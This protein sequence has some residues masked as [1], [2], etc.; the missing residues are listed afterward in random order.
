[1]KAKETLASQGEFLQTL[2]TVFV[3]PK[4]SGDSPKVLKLQLEVGEDVCFKPG[5]W[6]PLGTLEIHVVESGTE[7]D[8]VNELRLATELGAY[9]WNLPS[10]DS[11]RG[12]LK[13][14]IEAGAEGGAG[15]EATFSHHLQQAMKLAAG[16]AVRCGL[17]KPVIDPSLVANLPFSR[18]TTIV[19]DTS[20]VV[21][22]GLSFVVDFLGPSVRARVPAVVSMELMTRTDAYFSIR[23]GKKLKRLQR[24][25]GL[26]SHIFSQAGQRVL[27]RL[28][29]QTEIEVERP[30]MGADPLRGIAELGPDQDDKNLNVHTVIRSYADRLILETAIHH[31]EALEP[32]HDLVVLTADQGLARATQSEG[33]R[34]FFIDVSQMPRIFDTPLPGTVFAPFISRD[35]SGRLHTIPLSELVW[36]LASSFGAARLVASSSGDWLEVRALGNQ[37]PWNPFHSS[38]DLLWVRFGG[39]RLFP[40]DGLV[41]VPSHVVPV[42]TTETATP[43]PDPARPRSRAKKDS[44]SRLTGSYRFGLTSLLRLVDTLGTRPDATRETIMEVLNIQNFNNYLG[45]KNFLQSGGLIGEIDGRLVVLRPLVDLRE[46]LRNADIARAQT[47]LL[48]IPSYQAFLAEL[49]EGRPILRAGVASVSNSALD[50]YSALADLVA[51]ASEIPEEGLY[52]TPKSPPAG[53]FPEPAF[54]AYNEVRR[55]ELYASTGAW[56]EGLIRR[57]I[58][59]VVARERLGQARALGRVRLYVEGS[60]P[61]ESHSRHKVHLLDTGGVTLSVREASL[62]DGS[63]LTPGVASVSLRLEV[64]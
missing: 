19:V 63:F 4:R 25:K 50:S 5:G 38:E 14:L 32:G 62:Y 35:G 7:S 44:G 37:M 58:H 34:P 33:L 57:G 30:R 22:G 24:I 49:R 15:D 41:E 27:T 23:R 53:E 51:A 56:L 18:P 52:A 1:M 31:R 17:A 21:H 45:Y 61:D 2:S 8:P 16:A 36:D 40:K 12:K 46:A 10:E 43:A 54:A 3:L 59:P 6:L 60:T 48:K 42:T 39:S 29:L 55:G 26:E 47:I 64:D 28:A 20:A 13:E 11:I 9:E